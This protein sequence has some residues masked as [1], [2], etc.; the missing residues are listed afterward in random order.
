MNK[1]ILF[2]SVLSFSSIS[3]AA[4]LF[5]DNFDDGNTDGWSF[6]GT[7]SASWS[8]ATGVLNHHAPSGYTGDR[9][10]ALIDGI[11]TPDKFTLEADVSVISSIYGN[12]W[13]HV[14]FVWGVTDLIAPYDNLNTSYLRTHQ[15]LVTNWSIVNG[16]ASVEQFMYTPGATN[17]VTYHMR[18]EVDYLTKT[19]V[20]TLDGY[21]TVFTGADFDLINPN[22]G[23]GIG[24]ISWNDNI[25]FDNVVLTD[26]NSAIPVPAA[27]WLFVSGLLCFS[28][29]RKTG[30]RFQY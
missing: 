14:G 27:V 24:F 16:N 26:G 28:G 23:G 12:D 15:D 20:T 2:I 22:T 8:A 7:N 9:E 6:Y 4:V 11:N 1:I 13:G 17:G 10:L 25:T 21:S 3:N 29:W 18:I 5:S 19:M 30:V